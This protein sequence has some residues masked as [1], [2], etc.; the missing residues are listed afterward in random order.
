MVSKS[1]R[2]SLD[3]MKNLSLLYYKELHNTSKAVEYFIPLIDKRYPKEKVLKFFK[4]KYHADEKTIKKGYEL[5]LNSKII[6]EKLKYKG[7]L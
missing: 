1:H 5:Q 3:A 4:V 2:E 7:G 6:P